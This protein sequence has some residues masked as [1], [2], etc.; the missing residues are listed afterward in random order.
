MDDAFWVTAAR[1]YLAALADNA[2]TFEGSVAYEQVLL[3]F[4]VRVPRIYGHTEPVATT[5][6]AELF[7]AANQAIDCVDADRFDM[8]MVFARLDDAW[9]LD[10]RPNAACV[11]PH[12]QGGPTTAR[13]QPSRRDAFR[14]R[15]RRP[16][17]PGSRQLI[18]PSRRVRRAPGRG[19]GGSR[20]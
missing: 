17:L 1:S 12:Q 3:E 7:A 19:A 13:S 14:L 4:D 5:D 2:L 16:P 11:T 6:P 10:H 18:R 20:C 15:P 9:E 8:E